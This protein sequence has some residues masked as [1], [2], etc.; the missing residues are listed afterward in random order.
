MKTQLEST[1]EI[2]SLKIKAIKKGG[3]LK[4]KNEILMVCENHKKLFG[5]DL[6]PK[7]L[8]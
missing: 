5:N 3:Y 6:T 1:K 2:N 4:F 7:Q 8:N